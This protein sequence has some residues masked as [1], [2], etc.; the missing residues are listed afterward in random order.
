[1]LRR[2]RHS[3]PA[4]VWNACREHNETRAMTRCA[5]CCL[6]LMLVRATNPCGLRPHDMHTSIRLRYTPS[7]RSSR[8]LRAAM[9]WIYFSCRKYFQ[10]NQ[11][12]LQIDFHSD[13]IIAEINPQ[14]QQFIV[15]IYTHISIHLNLR[16][17][18]TIT[19]CNIKC[20]WFW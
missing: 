10:S 2:L 3:R 4:S 1:M 11:Y 14:L 19:Q 8:R 5:S 13:Q 20:N 17:Q 18:F 15:E 12:H 16:N 6:S 9:P 7:E